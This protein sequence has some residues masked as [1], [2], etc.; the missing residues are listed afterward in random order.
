M[1]IRDSRIGDDEKVVD[2]CAVRNLAEQTV[3]EDARLAGTGCG[4]DE[5]RAAL[6]FN[7]RLLG[8]R[9]CERLSLI[10]I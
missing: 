4:R 2:V 8:L 3:D 5:Q 7:D 1:C 6:V 9:Q 10:H